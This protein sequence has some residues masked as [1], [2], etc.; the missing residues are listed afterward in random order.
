MIPLNLSETVNL[1]WLE[2]YIYGSVLSSTKC[3]SRIQTKTM[4]NVLK[5]ELAFPLNVKTSSHTSNAFALLLNFMS[6]HAIPQAL[7]PST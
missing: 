7:P 2:I 3:T 5:I 6:C 1:S 4:Y